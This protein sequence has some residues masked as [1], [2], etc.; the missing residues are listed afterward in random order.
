MAFCVANDHVV[1]SFARGIAG[2]VGRAPL[3][4]L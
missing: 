4:T 3:R 1:A 2:G